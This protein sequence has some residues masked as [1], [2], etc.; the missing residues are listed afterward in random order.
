MR[1]SDRAG[2]A[3]RYP[4]RD[5]YE[6]APERLRSLADR[7]IHDGNVVAA[8]VH[9]C[10][11]TGRLP[12][13][14]IWGESYASPQVRWMIERLD[15]W[16]V[17]DLLEDLAE[18]TSQVDAEVNEAFAMCGLAYEM[19]DG[20]IYTL[21]EAGDVLEITGDEHATT[22]SLEGKYAPVRKQYEKALAGLNG[23]PMDLEKAVS[24]SVGAMEAVARIITGQ[25]DFGKAIDQALAGREGAGALGASLKA[26]YGY[27]SQLPGA[28]HGRHSEP[29][30]T[31]AEARVVVRMSADAIAYLIDAAEHS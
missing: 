8:Y 24:E 25:K 15:W 17:F 26:L 22:K 13:P 29:D 16:Q 23:R 19:V 12:D 4:P 20:S 28:R 7:V 3:K 11:M 18:G 14:N 5:N 10:E 1:F 30:L 27:A 9:L 21:D 31:L 6:D 2:V